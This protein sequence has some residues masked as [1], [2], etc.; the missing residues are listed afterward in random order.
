MNF[1]KKT[2]EEEIYQELFYITNIT[3]NLESD[4]DTTRKFQ[5]NIPDK[6]RWE[7]PP[8]SLIPVDRALGKLS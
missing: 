3:L 2:E 7:N 4:K 6:H 8:C 1:S 5:A